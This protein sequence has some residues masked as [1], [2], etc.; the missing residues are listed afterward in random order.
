[1][2]EL[3]KKQG[4]DTAPLEELKRKLNEANN[5]TRDAARTQEELNRQRDNFNKKLTVSTGSFANAIGAIGQ[6]AGSI[7]SAV[8]AFKM[9]TDAFREGASPMERITGILMGLSMLL[10]IVSQAFKIMNDE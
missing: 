7:M 5:A 9:L 6:Y 10:P 2:V 1:M 3:L 8:S 4:I